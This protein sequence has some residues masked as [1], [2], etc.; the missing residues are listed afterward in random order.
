MPRTQSAL[1]RDVAS[2]K[3]ITV[4][5]D[6]TLA[7]C[8]R[9]MHD[10]HVGSVVVVD[11]SRTQERPVGIVTDRDIVL[12]AV[13]HS[14]DPATMTAADIMVTSLGTVREEDDVIDA[15]ARMR[16]NGVR[17]LPVTTG[18]GRL[19]GIVALDDLVRVL[20]EQLTGVASVLAAEQVRESET[21]P[22]R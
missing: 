4:E 12:E 10:E 7:R 13:A 1:V 15:L 3:V 22:R 2:H 5:R 11:R 6:T 18:D 21:R 9:L 17:R 16:E 20:A 14:L 19:A 8:A